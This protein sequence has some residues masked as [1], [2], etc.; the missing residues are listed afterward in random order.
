MS[1][2]LAAGSFGCLQKKPGHT[3]VPAS[4]G[5]AGEDD[6]QVSAAG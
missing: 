1:R 2:D 5:L 4:P 3:K 6:L